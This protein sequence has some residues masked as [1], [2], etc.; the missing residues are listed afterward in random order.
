MDQVKPHI[1]AL[2]DAEQSTRGQYGGNIRFDRIGRIEDGTIVVS[3]SG[4]NHQDLYDIEALLL[5][6]GCRYDT[7]KGI[8]E[9]DRTCG[10]TFTHF[11]EPKSGAK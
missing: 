5:K 8:Q 7:T 11:K 6:L 10:R 3:C 1:Q 9:F 4:Y 2:L